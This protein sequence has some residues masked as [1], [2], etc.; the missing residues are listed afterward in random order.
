M[1]VISL[2]SKLDTSKVVRDEQLENIRPMTVTLLVSKLDTSKFVR[3]EQ[4]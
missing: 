4:L 2:V 1:S 3:D